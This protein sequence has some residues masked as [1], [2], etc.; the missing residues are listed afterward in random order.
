MV[1]GGQAGWRML[2]EWAL[3]GTGQGSLS[4]HEGLA[5]AQGPQ[6][7][8]SSK[9]NLT[10]TWGAQ[11]PGAIEVRSWQLG[12]RSPVQKFRLLYPGW[13][14]SLSNCS[15]VCLLSLTVTQ[16]PLPPTSTT[17]AVP[18]KTSTEL[19]VRQ[20][21]YGSQTCHLLAQ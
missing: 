1:H 15:S 14:E 11:L 4:F 12:R 21:W 3:C 8:P 16:N 18:G 9:V 5:A 20:A 6:T 10:L 19:S 17:L 13:G 2:R 7:L